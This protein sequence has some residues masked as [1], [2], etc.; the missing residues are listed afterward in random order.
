MSIELNFEGLVGI[1][2]MNTRQKHF[3]GKEKPLAK[4]Q[5]HEDTWNTKGLVGGS[6]WV[7]LWA[8]RLGSRAATLLQ[9]SYLY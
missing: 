8:V 3:L 2:K 6:A 7:K 1:S 9:A 4:P 5:D